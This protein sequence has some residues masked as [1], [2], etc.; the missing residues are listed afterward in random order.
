MSHEHNP[1]VRRSFYRLKETG[2]L[3]F[4][5][6]F[7]GDGYQGPF[8]NSDGERR[9]FDVYHFRNEE[10]YEHITEIKEE[11]GNLRKRAE[12]GTKGRWVTEWAD[13]MESKLYPETREI[14]TSKEN[15]NY[16]WPVD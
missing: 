6:D 3:E 9:V 16:P 8:E 12:D 15:P 1:M 4:F 14:L 10:A 2:A 5:V 7:R 11:A 13:W